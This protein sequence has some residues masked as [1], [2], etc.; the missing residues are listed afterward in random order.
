[1]Q[2]LCFVCLFQ[3]RDM[4]VLKTNVFKG[5]QLFQWHSSGNM[6]EIEFHG[7]YLHSK[8]SFRAEYTFIRL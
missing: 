8:G 6:A 7:D 1:M 5:H 3:I 2:H 4:D